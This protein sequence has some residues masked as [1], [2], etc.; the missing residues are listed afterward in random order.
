VRKTIK[1]SAPART[2]ERNL[3]YAGPLL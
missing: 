1:H 2:H 3:C